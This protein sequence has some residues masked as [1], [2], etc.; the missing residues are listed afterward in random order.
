[1]VVSQMDRSLDI[2]NFWFEV[3]DDNTEIKKREAPFNKWFLKSL[4][5]DQII[6]ETFEKDLIAANQGEYSSWESDLQQRLALILLFDQFSRNIYRGS[7]QSFAFDD[8]A[9]KLSLLT[10]NN[11]DDKKLSLIRRLFVYM[12]LTHCEDLRIQSLSVEKFTELSGYC[13]KINPKNAGY[14]DNHLLYAQKHYRIIHTFRRFPHR[15]D[16]LKRRS[17]ADEM[18]FLNQKVSN[19]K[20]GVEL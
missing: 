17:N 5:T 12:P 11:R 2:L 18:H 6:K 7:A 3:V 20:T 8:K 4:E 10:I 15:N 1:M 9:L 16:I 19:F 14:Y 13:K